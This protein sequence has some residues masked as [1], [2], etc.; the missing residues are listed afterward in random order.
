MA[1]EVIGVEYAILA[2]LD[3]ERDGSFVI[4]PIFC[5]GCT[6]P[7]RLHWEDSSPLVWHLVTCREPLSAGDLETD[8]AFDSLSEFERIELGSWASE[9]LIPVASDD[10]VLG[11]LAVGPK[12]TG[13]RYGAA[14][15]DLLGRWATQ[16]GPVLAYARR[17]D[18]L[19]RENEVALA[20]IREL[21]RAQREL[22]ELDRLKSDLIS[23]L[24]H[25]LRVPFVAID[26]ALAE[27]E[28]EKEPEPLHH[29]TRLDQSI[30]D[31]RRL[32]DHLIGFASMIGKQGALQLQPVQ[33]ADMVDHVVRSLEIM[34]L[35]RRVTIISSLQ[36]HQLSIIGDRERL[37]DAVYQILHNAIK[38]NRAGGE[39]NVCCTAGPQW[40]TLEVADTG[41]GI[42]PEQLRQLG[43]PGMPLPEGEDQGSNGMGM[44]LGLALA[45]YVAQVHGGRLEVETELGLGSTFRLHLPVGGPQAEADSEVSSGR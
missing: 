8:P 13:D 37:A 10:H 9:L 30:G 22:L 32:V 21:E 24:T 31:L 25:D 7:D 11:L 1:E 3:S 40:V 39:V 16:T 12:Q 17:M 34:S 18:R 43:M 38:F 28:I 27:L 42:P 4:R 44:G 19:I 20:R 5:R 33:L 36:D 26:Q 35:A 6:T 15:L 29:T 14:D 45:R 23:T 2:T 41:C